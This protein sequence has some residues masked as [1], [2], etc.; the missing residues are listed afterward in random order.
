MSNKI[1]R[2]IKVARTLVH[3][4]TPLSEDVLQSVIAYVEEKY[5]LHEKTIGY[6]PDEEKKVD[7]LIITLLDIAAELISARQEI[8]KLKQLDTE[9]LA[10]V[11]ILNR[12]LDDF[13]KR[14]EK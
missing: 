13:S 4:S 9:A 11:D 14:I 10:A 3:I 1:H 7:T 6:K 12:Q 8:K 5:N 2:Q